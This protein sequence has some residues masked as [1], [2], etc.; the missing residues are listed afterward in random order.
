MSGKAESTPTENERYCR[1][2]S[3]CVFRIAD[4]KL[5]MKDTADT[6]AFLG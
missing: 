4:I 5:K 2:S 1:H 6:T 3:G